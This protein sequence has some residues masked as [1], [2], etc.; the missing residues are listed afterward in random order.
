[1]S[2]FEIRQGRSKLGRRRYR[3]VL[4]ADNGEP[5]SV[6]EA[7]NSLDAAYVNI[8]AQ[9]QAAPNAPIVEK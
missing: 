3:V 6:S 4:I 8:D 9:R 2:R 1:M 7:L 5:L